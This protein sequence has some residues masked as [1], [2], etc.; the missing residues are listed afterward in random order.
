LELTRRSDAGEHH[1]LAD[2]LPE[3]ADSLLQFYDRW[4]EPFL[5]HSI[6]P[7]PVGASD[8]VVIPAHEGFLTGSARYF[9]SPNGWSN[10]WVTGLDSFGSS[11][12]WP[13]LTTETS[14]YECFIRFASPGISAV[15]LDFSGTILEREL[16]PYIPVEDRNYSRIDRSTEA[17]GQTWSRTRLG[18]VHLEQG[19][20]TL[21]ITGSG[22]SL[23]ILSLTLV[24][25]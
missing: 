1:N 17:I 20:D 15:K 6:P 24:K 12:Y 18:E 23:E 10:D 5:N 25:K 11:I 14:D 9:W 19:T 4:F 7:I 21:T 8:S 16:Q 2:S 3:L 22:D 13:L